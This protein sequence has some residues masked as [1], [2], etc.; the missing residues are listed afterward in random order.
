MHATIG[1]LGL[2]LDISGVVL[3]FKYGFPQPD[4]KEGVSLGVEDNTPVTTEDDRRITAKE[5][6]DEVQKKKKLYRKIA[7]LALGLILFGFIFQ[8]ISS[9]QK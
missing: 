3:L 8:L 9:L 6:V 1:S 5:Y 4:F 7:F 2:I